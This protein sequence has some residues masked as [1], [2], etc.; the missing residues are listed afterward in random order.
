MTNDTDFM[1]TGRGAEVISSIADF[2]ESRVTLDKDTRLY[3][4]N[5]TIIDFCLYC[6]KSRTTTSDVIL[7]FKFMQP[8]L[9]V[10]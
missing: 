7:N 6:F 1:T 3:H 5:G 2:W 10:Y 8:I 9:K 4:I